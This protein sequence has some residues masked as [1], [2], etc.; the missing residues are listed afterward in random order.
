[1]RNAFDI[2]RAARRLGIETLAPESLADDG[3]RHGARPFVV[4]L[5]VTAGNE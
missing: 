4:G 3:H 5:D 2:D 1:M